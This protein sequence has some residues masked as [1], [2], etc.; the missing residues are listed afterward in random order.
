MNNKTSLIILAVLITILVI[1]SVIIVEYL[2]W[3]LC[4]FQTS[5]I[6]KLGWF[7][8]CNI[9]FAFLGFEEIKRHVDG[10]DV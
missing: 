3:C 8:V 2:I 7:M 10:N 5:I 6:G 9:I 1:V 4:P